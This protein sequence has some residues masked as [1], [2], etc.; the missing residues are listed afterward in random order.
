MPVNSFTN[1]KTK[2]EHHKL[3]KSVSESLEIQELLGR[4][5]GK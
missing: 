5:A 4:L 3:T 2:L 1:M